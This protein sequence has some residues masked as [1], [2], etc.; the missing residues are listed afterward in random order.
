MTYSLYR[1]CKPWVFAIGI[2]VAGMPVRHYDGLGV[3]VPVER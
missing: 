1:R 3:I 2:R